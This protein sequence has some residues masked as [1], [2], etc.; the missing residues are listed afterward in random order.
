MPQ[1][2]VCLQNRLKQ[3][4]FSRIKLVYDGTFLDLKVYYDLD[5]RNL[6]VVYSSHQ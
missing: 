1:N 4:A 5:W 6:K 3:I 2:V